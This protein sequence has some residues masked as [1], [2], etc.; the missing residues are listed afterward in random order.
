[1]YGSWKSPV[2]H[3]REWGAVDWFLAQ[4]AAVREGVVESLGMQL[5]V[6]GQEVAFWQHGVVHIRPHGVLS[7]AGERALA[8]VRM[9]Q[10]LHNLRVVEMGSDR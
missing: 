9:G 7:E 2:R 8:G 4:R 5:M 3:M 10:Y 1:M 6:D